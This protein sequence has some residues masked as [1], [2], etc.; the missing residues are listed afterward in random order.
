MP[1][2]QMLQDATQDVAHEIFLFWAAWTHTENRFAYQSWYVLARNLMDFFDTLPDDRDRDAV[3]AGDFF[4]PPGTWHGK[5]Q[6]ISCPSDYAEYRIAAHK[7]AAHLTYG[8]AD[9]RR[10]SAK[11]FDPSGEISTYLLQQAS[12]FLTSLLPEPQEW[13]RATEFL[14]PWEGP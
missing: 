7:R 13:F 2:E 1:T 3:L 6:T 8:R 14:L 5:R 9:F 12:L 11:A 4:D 10:P